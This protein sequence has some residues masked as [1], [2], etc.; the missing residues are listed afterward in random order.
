ME[1]ERE[2][3]SERDAAE[4]HLCTECEEKLKEEAEK[5]KGKK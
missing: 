1:G 2:A 3:D 5:M 4:V